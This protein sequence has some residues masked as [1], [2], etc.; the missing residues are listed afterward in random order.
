MKMTSVTRMFRSHCL[1]RFTPTALTVTTALTLCVTCTCVS[2]GFIVC[3]LVATYY[4]FLGVDRFFWIFLLLRTCS[5]FLLLASISTFPGIANLAAPILCFHFSMSGILVLDRG[6]DPLPSLPSAVRF[7]AVDLL[8]SARSSPR[9]RPS[10][11]PPPH[12][13]QPAEGAPLL[14]CRTP[15]LFPGFP[16][17]TEITKRGQTIR[18]GTPRS[19][20]GSS[21]RWSLE[22]QRGRR[23]S[24]LPASEEAGRETAV[25]L[26]VREQGG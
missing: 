17:A 24:T 10:L 6:P 25:L 14:S 2:W 19:L 20:L 23:K 13:V 12:L 22:K 3:P 21:R 11:C 5:F 1:P 7:L 9:P 4:C 18:P 15:L 26:Q 16:K 8:A